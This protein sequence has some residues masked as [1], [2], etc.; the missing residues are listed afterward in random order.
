M[1]YRKNQFFFQ[2]FFLGL[3]LDARKLSV[4]FRLKNEGQ[5][6]KS[7][8]NV[9]PINDINEKDVLDHKATFVIGEKTAR[10]FF[11]NNGQFEHLSIYCHISKKKIK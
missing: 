3:A 8:G 5:E 7:I 6:M 4:T 10:Q 11:V 2:M 9:I 1:L